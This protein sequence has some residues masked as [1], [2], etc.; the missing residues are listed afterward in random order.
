LRLLG[1]LAIALAAGCIAPMASVQPLKHEGQDVIYEN[2]LP[3]TTSSGRESDLIVAPVTSATGRYRISNRLMFMVL[4][5]NRSPNRIEVSEASFTLRTSGALA[6]TITS[7]E[8]EDTI[9]SQAAWAQAMNGISTAL[10]SMNAGMYGGRSS[11]TV[12]G[13]GE[14]TTVSVTD[15]AEAQRAQRE[16]AREGATNSAVITARERAALDGLDRMLQRNTV[17]PG[18]EVGGLVVLDIPR[19]SACT[20]QVPAGEVT[21][22]DPENPD[23]PPKKTQLYRT[24]SIPCKFELTAAVAGDTHTISFDEVFSGG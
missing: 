7:V 13:K 18:A 14:I 5:R 11:A 4:I 2:G 9:R 1:F 6:H 19:S 3:V 8:M 12:H 20:R 23:A 21:E 24:E 17:L 16:V 15:H 22:S 10:A